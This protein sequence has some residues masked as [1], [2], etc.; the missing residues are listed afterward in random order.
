MQR[1]TSL[2]AVILRTEGTKDPVIYR[3]RI[4]RFYWILHGFAVQDD[5]PKL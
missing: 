2:E 3:F 1:G 4:T 5:A